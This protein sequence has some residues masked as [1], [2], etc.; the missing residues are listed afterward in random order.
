MYLKIAFL[1]QFELKDYFFKI[2]FNEIRAK[3]YLKIAFAC[4]NFAKREAKI[5]IF[6]KL[7]CKFGGG[8]YP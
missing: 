2:L 7:V 4:D 1:G 5:I 3:R 6:E 8:E